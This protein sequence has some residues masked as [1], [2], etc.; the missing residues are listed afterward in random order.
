M[1]SELH[2]KIIKDIEARQA[3]ESRQ[4][5]W[6]QMRNSGLRRRNKPWPGAADLHFPLVDSMIDKWKPFYF[7]QLFS[8]ET[9]AAFVGKPGGS[10]AYASELEWWFDYKLKEQSNLI[11]S[12]LVSIDKMLVSGSVTVMPRWDVAKRRVQFE[13]LEPTKC[14]VPWY[15]QELQDAD[16]F[17]YIEEISVEQYKSREGYNQD[18]EF[19]KRITGKGPTENTEGDEVKF[20]REGLTAASNDDLICLWHAWERQGQAWVVHCFSPLDPATAVKPTMGNPYDHGRLPAIRFDAEI[21]DLGHYDSRGLAEIAGPFETSLTKSWNDKHDFMTMVNRP[22]FTSEREIP[23]AQNIRM[24]PGQ[25]LGF[26]VQRVEM[27]A[28]PVSFDQEILATREIAEYRVGMPDFGVGQAGRANDNKT[29]TEVQAISGLMSQGVDLKAHMFRLPQGEL[30]QQAWALLRQFDRESLDYM[31]EAAMRQLPPEAL[32]QD[33]TVMPKGSSDSWNRPAKLQRAIARKQLL[34]P[35]GATPPWINAAELDKSII[36]LDDPKLVAKIWIDPQLKAANEAEDEMKMLPAT[37]LAA[38][39]PAKPGQD[40][41]A[42]IQTIVQ[43]LQQRGAM[44]IAPTPVE[45]A[46]INQRLGSLVQALSQEDPQRGAMVQQELAMLLSGGAN[47]PEQ[48]N[49]VPGAAPAAG[50]GIAA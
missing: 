17:T 9:L 30:Y 24:I 25:I 46:G 34:A 2:T 8:T 7:Q 43:F 10:D 49:Q 15:T 35:A 42:R 21:K 16:R 5:M 18:P 22:M 31:R 32:N 33:Y 3:W 39:I 11:R 1:S 50:A 41:T 12:V 48:T 27:G 38:P 14:V 45:I 36:E 23:N 44:G 47:G 19:V 28:P 13:V 4:A 20:R 40:H 37:L 26:P 6:Y 29:A